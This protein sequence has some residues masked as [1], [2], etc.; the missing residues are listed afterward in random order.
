MLQ[1]QDEASIVDYMVIVRQLVDLLPTLKLLQA[2][3]MT[4]IAREPLIPYQLIMLVKDCIVAV[5]L[6][7]IAKVIEDKAIK[8]SVHVNEHN[9]TNNIKGQDDEDKA[10]YMDKEQS[11]VEGGSKS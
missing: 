9:E 3:D 2:Y 8:P 6:L 7:P 4:I 11:D 10:L 1:P 5:T